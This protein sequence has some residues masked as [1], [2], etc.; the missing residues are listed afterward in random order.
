MEGGAQGG[1]CD[2]HIQYSHGVCALRQTWS[3]LTPE[4]FHVLCTGPHCF[5]QLMSQSPGEAGNA[6]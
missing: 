6:C 2:C 1:K 5:Q 4:A 3:V